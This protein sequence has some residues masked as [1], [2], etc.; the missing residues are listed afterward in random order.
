VH[1]SPDPHTFWDL[2]GTRAAF[3]EHCA[4]YAIDRR[5]RGESGDAAEYELKREAEDAAAVIN[6]IDDPVTWLG[7]PSG[8]L[9]PLEAALRTD[10]PRKLILNEPPVAGR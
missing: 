4:V 8:A 7:H 2:S 6:A 3:A 9:Y 1:G 5:G 10:D